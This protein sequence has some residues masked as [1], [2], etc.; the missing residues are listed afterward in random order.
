DVNDA[1]VEIDLGDELVDERQEALD[2]AGVDHEQILECAG[3]DFG[4][5]SPHRTVRAPDLAADQVVEQDVVLLEDERLARDLDRL[6]LERLGV[7]AGDDAL[8]QHEPAALGVARVDDLF[9]DAA[10][11]DRVD[12]TERG[13]VGVVR[14][15]DDLALDPVRPRDAT[16]LDAR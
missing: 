4:D 16:D 14:E 11:E 5:R 13:R 9:L 1:R 2:L 8:E 6:A 10:D 7:V 12:V 3:L 15:D